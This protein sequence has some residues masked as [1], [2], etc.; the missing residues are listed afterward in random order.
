MGKTVIYLTPEI[1]QEKPHYCQIC[2]HEYEP[3][4][5]GP[6]N[7]RWQYFGA[8]LLPWSDDFDEESDVHDFTYLYVSYEPV[9][10]VDGA[11]QVELYTRQD[12][13]D[14]YYKLMLKKANNSAWWKRMYLKWAAGKNY[15]VV[16]EKGGS[17]FRHAH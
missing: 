1:I 6:S 10:Y 12:C 3:N 8:Q 16:C 14:L 11:I 15:R 5:M 4:G 9:T 7:N 2:G 13:D 17:S